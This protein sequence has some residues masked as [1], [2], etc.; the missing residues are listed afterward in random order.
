MLLELLLAHS[1]NEIF[2]GLPHEHRQSAV[3]T[4]PEN[5]AG[6]ERQVQN[7]KLKSELHIALENK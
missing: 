7:F 2:M 5:E 4:Q 1:G 6:M 3:L